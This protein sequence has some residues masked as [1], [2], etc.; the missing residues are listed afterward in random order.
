MFSS[1]HATFTK[2]EAK[3][4]MKLL[5]LEI[6]R[7]QKSDS[8]ELVK[9]QDASVGKVGTPPPAPSLQ[10][11]YPRGTLGGRR[12]DPK[13]DEAQ[14]KPEF[15]CLY[16]KWNKEEF[17]KEQGRFLQGLYDAEQHRRE[18]VG[19][20]VHE[21]R[22]MWSMAEGSTPIQI[23]RITSDS[24]PAAEAQMAWTIQNEFW[25][26]CRRNAA[27]YAAAQSGPGVQ[28]GTPAPVIE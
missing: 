6:T 5:G 11:M 26:L 2:E 4:L 10:E 15:T 18:W 16:R 21:L 28:A 8:K 25:M 13:P 17:Q 23:L 12:Y 19:N 22:L 3:T 9:A 24:R 27:Q 7:R 1:L 20:E 14:I